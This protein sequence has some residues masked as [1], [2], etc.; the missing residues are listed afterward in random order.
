MIEQRF[1]IDE[2]GDA[3]GSELADALQM[4]RQLESAIDRIGTTLPAVE[5]GFDVATEARGGLGDRVM[6][7]LANEPAPAPT[8]F[9]LPLRRAGILGGLLASFRQASVATRGAGRPAPARV[10]ALAYVLVVAFAGLSLTGAATIGAAGALGLLGPSTTPSPEPS[11]PAPTIAPPTQVAPVPTPSLP[12]TTAPVPSPTPSE[13]AEAS[14]DNGG[15][16]GPGGGGDD[17][18]NSGPGSSADD[19]SSGSGR[20]GTDSSGPGSGD[21]S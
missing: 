19:D 5:T 20:G 2:L 12:P 16:S 13:S 6:A 11:L 10:A 9:L 18:D 8:G 17:D 4:G 21:D 14:D 3:F 15:N 7:A 1:G